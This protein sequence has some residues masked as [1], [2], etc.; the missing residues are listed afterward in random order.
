MWLPWESGD[1][2]PGTGNGCEPIR[3]QSPE[4]CVL[5]NEIRTPACGFVD[6]FLHRNAEKRAPVSQIMPKPCTNISAAAIFRKKCGVTKEKFRE[7]ENLSMVK[8]YSQIYK[9]VMDLLDKLVEILGEKQ[10]RLQEF[11]DEFRRRAF[12]GKGGI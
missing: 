3:G 8:E 11:K 12:G 1:L 5:L 10:V 9:I 4:E 7:E 6:T 2:Q